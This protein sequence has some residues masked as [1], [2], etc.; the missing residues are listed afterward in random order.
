MISI[1]GTGRVGSAIGFLTA[2]TSLDDVV[3]VNRNKNKAMGEALDIANTIPK[4]SSI[5]ITGTD[6]FEQISGSKVIVITTGAGKIVTD[7]SDLIPYTVPII[8]EISKKIAKYAD[9]AKIVVVTNPVDVITYCLL[10]SEEH[11]SELQSP[12]N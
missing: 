6:D 8:R 10:R 9:D 11:T 7:R 5:S 12:L 1:I 2:A 3:L 4:N